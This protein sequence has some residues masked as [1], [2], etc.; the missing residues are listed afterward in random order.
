MDLTTI[1]TQLGATIVE[2]QSLAAAAAYAVGLW[3][4]AKAVNRGIKAS[5]QPG[6]GETSG[7]AIFTTLLIGAVLLNLTN[8][9]GDLWETMTGE[10]GAGFG[11]VS[12]SGASAAGV[13]APA[14]NAIFT[15]VSTFGWWYG[16]KGLTMFKK[17]SEGHG[18]GGYEDYAWKGFIH[19][20]GGAAMVNIGSTV[21]AF[22]ETV[23]LTF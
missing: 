19:A 4:I 10:R 23:G 2:F 17:A 7:A 11:M 15:I 3:Y 1:V 16:F 5:S 12:Y 14:I 13:F 9:M 18:S 20:I 21:D 22:K 6:G 8:T